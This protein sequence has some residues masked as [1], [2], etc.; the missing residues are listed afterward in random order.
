MGERIDKL[1]QKQLEPPPPATAA[2]APGAPLGSAGAALSF[3]TPSPT[4][5]WDRIPDPTVVK[6]ST[7]G[8]L[9]V[10]RE[11]IT[12]CIDTYLSELSIPKEV[13]SVEGRALGNTFSIMF[14]GLSTVASKYVEKT[15][16]S[17]KVDGVWREL[18]VLD[19]SKNPVRLYLNPDKNGRQQ[20][21]EGATKRLCRRL[22]SQHSDLNLF[23]RKSEGII[24]LDFKQLALVSA[25]EAGKVD[26]GWN[27][28]PVRTAGI[29]KA[30]FTKEF[31]ETENI[32]WCS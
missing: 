2:G 30:S 6:I 24:T 3:P 20:K 1:E 5:H 12:A 22:K 23:A 17:L 29:D 28:G 26:L 14:L 18:K 8:K 9:K 27:P 19:P 15:L 32:Q 31:L 21:I 13:Y 16:K 11:V 10:S 7:D 25:P 4:T